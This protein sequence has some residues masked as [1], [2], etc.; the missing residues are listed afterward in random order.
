MSVDFVHIVDIL[1]YEFQI[2]WEYD[3]GFFIL[4]ALRFVPNL[5]CTHVAFHRE[6]QG[7]VA[8]IMIVII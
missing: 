8:G 6:I 3:F 1:D 2:F 5:C 7:V 4:L